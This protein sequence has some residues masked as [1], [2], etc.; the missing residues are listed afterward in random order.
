[1]SGRLPLAH[2]EVVEFGERIAVPYVGKLLAD[3]GATVIKVE[4]G[5][6][7]L[8][9]RFGPWPRGSEGDPEQSGMFSHLNTSKRSYAVD[10]FEPGPCLERLIERARVVLIDET[11]L[12]RWSWLEPH[13]LS[14]KHPD[15]VI[16]VVTPFG[17]SGPYAG[18]RAY[19]ITLDAAGGFSYGVGEP[20]R[21]PLPMP[22]GQ[23]EYQGALAAAIGTLLALL[24]AE[25][26]RRGQ[27]VDI[28]IHEV[29]ASL[30]CGYFLPRY[31]YEG[32]IVGRRAGRVGGAT[33]YPNT[34]LN[35]LDGL[36][37]LTAPQIKQWLRYVELIGRPAWAQQPRY[38]DRRAMQWQY[39]QE[40]DDLVAPWFRDKSKA[41]LLRLFHDHRLPFAP[42]LVGQD[43]VSLD[44][45]EHRGAVGPEELSGGGRYL[46]P[47]APY[48]FSHG[49]TRHAQAPTLGEANEEFESGPQA[50]PEWTTGGVAGRGEAAEDQGPPLA[51][52]RVLDLGTAWAGGIAGRLLGDFG[53]DVVKVESRSHMDGSRM[54]RPI[55]VDDPAGGDEGK[56][57]DLQPGFH[58]HGRSKRSISLNL[59]KEEGARLLR[60]LA[61]RSDVFIH[62]FSPGV[63]ARLDLGDQTLRARNR[64]LVVAGQ[65]LLGSDGPLSRYIGYAGTVA[66]LAGFASTIGYE[67]EE[68]IGMLEGLY[69]DVV[70]ALTT[71]FATLVALVDRTETGEGQVV[72]VSQVEATLALSSEVV[73]E[74]SI[75][76]RELGPSGFRHRVLC[77]HGNYRMG[78]N[79]AAEE[80]D[81][82]MSIAI[83][84]DE[85]WRALLDVMGPE[86]SPGPGA[87]GWSGEERLNCR[88][89]I[90]EALQSW[91]EK[92]DDEHIWQRLQESGVAAFPVCNIEAVFA[93][94]QLQAREAFVS[95]DHPLVGSEYMP[96]IPIKLSRTPGT[97]T[98]HAPLLGQHTRELLVEEGYVALD[99]FDHLV[100]QGVVEL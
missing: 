88:D 66:A 99:D 47:T 43:I 75:V 93:D 76:G 68:A 52:L 49:V 53:A 2:V 27:V 5:G 79:A 18:Y 72:D 59:K 20:D 67:G 69:S 23:S 90:D 56:W 7:D 30:H 92:L 80:G 32:G 96:G 41:T 36:V 60:D 100:H 83:G 40:T 87:E 13:Q 70:S 8:S 21:A 78:A 97:V 98:R 77:P 84:S 86:Y 46:A 19:G 95:V 58:V 73:M 22:M 11:F 31:I 34:V 85:E 28:S 1:M 54:G 94:P 12:Q 39:K 37:F 17:R 9:R 91:L 16:T 51:G 64:R 14:R 65:S 81:R 62:N 44:H 63:L 48:R 25:R 29:V 24:A 89:V 26:D 35:C 45:F 6:G 82:W 57:P 38:R 74:Y 71:V 61:E 10:Q 3:L 42:L 50:A 15:T 55:L 33:P 4:V